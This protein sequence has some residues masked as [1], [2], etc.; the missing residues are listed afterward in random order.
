MKAFWNK[1]IASKYSLWIV[2]CIPAFM[3]LWGYFINGNPY[4]N[5]MHAS[6]EFSAR[7]LILT[8]I[9]TPSLLLI[10]N[11]KLKDWLKYLFIALIISAS[12]YLSIQNKN[13]LQGAIM[14]AVL[15][16]LSYYRVAIIK[17]LARN[18]RYFGLATFSYAMVHTVIYITEFPMNRILKEF[19]EFGVLTGWLAFIIWIPLAITSNN[20]SVRKLKKR[21]KDLQSFTYPA[22]LL[23]LA[24]WAFVHLNFIPALLHFMPVLVLQIYRAWLE[25]KNKIPEESTLIYK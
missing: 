7:A 21:W 9:V 11:V 6:G 22:A 5:M 12:I 19:L 2:L 23:V 10:K 25:R 16:A 13:P 20:A 8:L 18:R 15:L 24:H 14:M 1:W 4:G 17:W 3:F